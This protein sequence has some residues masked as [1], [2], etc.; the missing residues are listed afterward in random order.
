MTKTLIHDARAF[1]D[2]LAGNNNRDWFQEHKKIYEKQLR[3]PAKALLATLAPRIEALTGYDVKT[4]LFRINRDVRFSKDKTPYNTH[5]HMM[6]TVAAGVRQDP[7]LFFGIGRDYVTV[8]G[9][10][11]EFSKDVLA[12]WR[13][14]VDLDG[15]RIAGLLAKAEEAGFGLSNWTPALKRVPPPF[16]KD[17]PHGALLKQKGL[18]LSGQ[19]SDDVEPAGAIMDAIGMIWPVADMLVGIAEPPVA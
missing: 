6:W 15:A 18:T 7:V 19:L 13:K 5:L 1:L 14:M 4:K 10:M 3:D 2:G 12:D 11:M 16:P 8:G 9:G 17:H